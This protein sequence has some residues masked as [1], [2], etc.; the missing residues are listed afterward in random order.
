M[1]RSFESKFTSMALHDG[2][3]RALGLCL[4]HA[5]IDPLRL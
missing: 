4:S 5:Y 3:G 1:S 2:M